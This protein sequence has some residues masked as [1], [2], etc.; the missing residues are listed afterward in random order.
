MSKRLFLYVFFVLAVSCSKESS[1]EYAAGD[2][3]KGIVG[4]WKLVETRT[5]DGTGKIHV[6][7]KTSENRTISFDSKGKTTDDRFSCGG[8][9]TFAPKEPSEINGANLVIS[10]GCRN[11]DIAPT[12]A[13]Y[14]AFIKDNNHLTI[15]DENC[16]ESCA[17]V[18]RRLKE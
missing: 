16:D 8:E 1:D 3:Q 2:N 9:Y 14:H 12:S 6:V 7:D 18:Y 15:N 17:E 10:F 4:K 13:R 11:M 5:S